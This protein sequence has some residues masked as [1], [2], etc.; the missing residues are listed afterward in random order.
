MTQ[1]YLNHCVCVRVCVDVRF[2]LVGY[3]LG[4]PYAVR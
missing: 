4:T 2:L 3:Q 1:H